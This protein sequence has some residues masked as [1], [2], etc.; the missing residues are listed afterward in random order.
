LG[1]LI[2]SPAGYTLGR[3]SRG[4]EVLRSARAI[5]AI[6]VFGFAGTRPVLAADISLGPTLK[7]PPIALSWTGFYLGGDVGIRSSRSD[8]TTDAINFG[9]FIPTFTGSATSEPFDGTSPRVGGY[10]GYNWQFAPTWVAGLEADIA[11]SDKTETIGG[12][13]LPGPVFAGVS[14]LAVDSVSTRTT[15]DGSLRGRLGYLVSSSTLLYATGGVAWQ[16]EE[17]TVVCSILTFCAPTGVTYNNSTTK[18]GWTLGGG[19]ETSLWSHWLLRGQYRYANYGTTTYASSVLLAGFPVTSVYSVSLQTH[20]AM[21]GLAYKF[22]DSPA[23]PGSATP[24]MSVKAL[25]LKAP[26]APTSLDWSG[27]YVGLDA[28]MRSSV[29]DATENSVTINGAPNPCSGSFLLSNP[30][31][32]MSEPMNGTTFRFGGYLGYNWRF[33]SLWLVGIEGDIAAANQTTTLGGTALPGNLN[34]FL[35]PVGSF[36]GKA[37][38]SFTVT[39]KWDASARARLGYF[40]SPSILMYLTGGPTWLNV[41]STSSCGLSPVGSCFTTMSPLSITNTTAKTGWTFGGGFETILWSNWIARAE[42][43]Y[44]DYGTATYT[45]TV[46]NAPGGGFGPFIYKDT[47][48]LR[49]QTHTAMLG[50]AYKLG[51]MLNFAKP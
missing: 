22:G 20:T 15:W 17:S 24:A 8:L 29:T 41:S 18:A 39:T 23:P 40:V 3:D 46:V 35:F 12:M 45:N 26:A 2:A 14:G 16:H 19:I 10:F 7:A 51:D 32:V 25:P 47:Y 36:E 4:A 9:G 28:G 50:I 34:G 6:A 44:A 1:F 42:Y 13:F 31:C 21:L 49:L 27:A 38:D 30:P 43:R 33:S 37:G 48:S 5:I 11:W